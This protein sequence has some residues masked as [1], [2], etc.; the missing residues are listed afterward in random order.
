MSGRSPSGSCEQ[1]VLGMLWSG[2]QQEPRRP[3]GVV[4]VGEM[5]QEPVAVVLAI[6]TGDAAQKASDPKKKRSTVRV[7]PRPDSFRSFSLAKGRR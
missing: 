6:C 1:V 4:E 2:L 5:S 3:H 7:G